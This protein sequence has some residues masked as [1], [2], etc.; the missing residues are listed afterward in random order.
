MRLDL[1]LVRHGFRDAGEENTALAQRGRLQMQRLARALSRRDIRPTA[2]V[3]S[4][5]RHARESADELVAYLP[6]RLTRVHELD[7]LTPGSGVPSDVDT[8]L[9]ELAGELDLRSDQTVLV[10][11]HEG[12]L[13]DLLTELT[14]AR[15]RPLVPGGA[16]HVESDGRVELLRGGGR[17][18]YRYPTVDHQE[19]AL[20]AKVHS[21]MTISVF[22]AGFVFTSL[23]Y[24]LLE[25]REWPWHRVV[26]A[27]ALTGSLMLFVAAV[28]IFDQLGTPA[29]F[30][31][32]A[33]KPNRLWR[34]WYARRD[35]LLG[36]RWL[37]LLRSAPG[38]GAQ[39]AAWV[40]DHQPF[41]RERLDGPVYW[42]MVRTS[43]FVFTP[44]L[45]L[46]LLGFAA[47]VAGTGSRHVQ[48]TA[49]ACL[50]ATAVYAASRRPALGAD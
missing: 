44:A 24:L 6:V 12:R 36:E 15:S 14:G 30:A 49:G 20:R 3:S 22:L 17:V 8:V 45:F 47:I 31:T 33:E 26:A 2:I 16:A 10:V 48:V 42:H 1:I 43:R 34:W 4:R 32:D 5:A 27:S 46:A 29:G 35:R 18:A 37:T 11:G 13:S 25:V 38:D 50:L 40:D 28:Y 39:Q 23:S 7:A 19:D 21:K 9:D 41:A